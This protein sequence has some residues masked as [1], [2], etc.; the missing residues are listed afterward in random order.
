MAARIRELLDKL[1]YVRFGLVGAIS[2]LIYAV[3]VIVATK[4]FGTS[5]VAASVLGYAAAIPINFLGQK[6]YTFRSDRPAH[7]EMLQYAVVQLLNMAAAAF[8]TYVVDRF[9]LSIYV[10]IVAVIVVIPTMTYLMLKLAV[11]R[12]DG[13]PPLR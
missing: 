4:L 8:V 13:T 5:P 11:F 10:A 6:H 9:G 12:T 2:S 3:V 7:H 1:R